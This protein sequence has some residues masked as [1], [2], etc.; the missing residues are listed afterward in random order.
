[1]VVKFEINYRSFRRGFLV[2]LLGGICVLGGF[3]AT[4][5]LQK[6][7]TNRGGVG[8][9]S[10]AGPPGP[11]MQQIRALKERIAQ[12]PNDGAA[13]SQLGDLYFQASKFEEALELYKKAVE[14]NGEDVVSRNDLALCYHI[15][16]KDKEAF[17]QLDAAL[18]IAPREP[19]LW[20]TLGV[21]SYETGNLKRAREAFEQAYKL[22]PA[23]SVGAK[24]KKMLESLAKS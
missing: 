5:S 12:N 14:I 23:S 24:A 13:Y 16:K 22:D 8:N 11:V 4:G 6:A 19:H 20:L 21:I 17:A 2:F 10:S 15:A 9:V 7:F 18:R 1:M 3:L